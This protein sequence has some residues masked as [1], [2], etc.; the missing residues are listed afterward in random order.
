[1]NSPALKRRP[2][3]GADSVGELS[4][5]SAY[6]EY[7]RGFEIVPVLRDAVR[8]PAQ[9]APEPD[10]R[11]GERP[12]VRREPRPDPYTLRETKC[13]ELARLYD[14]Y[15][16]PP[17]PPEAPAKRAR[18]KRKPSTARRKRKTKTKTKKN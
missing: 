9:P 18:A 16:R 11:L 6:D 8:M 3:F 17:P 2:I 12:D 5:E 14:E 1:V 10:F 13:A 4:Y 15:A 7:V